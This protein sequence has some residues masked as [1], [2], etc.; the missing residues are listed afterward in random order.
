MANNPLVYNAVAQASLDAWTANLNSGF[1]DVYTGSQP[2]VNGAVSGTKL[3]RLTFG[4][5]AFAASSANG[6]NCTA[7]ANTISSGIASNTGTAGY[8]VLLKTDGT[9]IVAS[10]S[11]GTA[12]AD[13]NFATLAINSGNVVACSA[14][15][16]SQPQT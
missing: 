1:I 8:F 5:T 7:A 14:F 4:A 11:V 12:G 3:V 16:V 10:G 13:L 15:T 2:A 6:T 9:T